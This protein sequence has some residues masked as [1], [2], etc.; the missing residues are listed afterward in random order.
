MLRAKRPRAKIN[1][2]KNRAFRLWKAMNPQD[3]MQ[4][5]QNLEKDENPTIRFRRMTDSFP[6]HHYTLFLMK[7]NVSDLL[8]RQQLHQYKSFFSKY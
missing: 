8:S 3:L 7:Q 1:E 6:G 4:N 5:G 2:S